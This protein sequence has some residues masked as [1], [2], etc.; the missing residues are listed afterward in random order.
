M[1]WY[2]CVIA[3][4]ITTELCA[5]SCAYLGNGIVCREAEQ[6]LAY[7]VGTG[8]CDYFPYRWKDLEADTLMLQCLHLTGKPSCTICILAPIHR[9]DANGVSGCTE[10]LCALIIYDAGKGA[11]QGIPDLVIVSVLL[12]QVTWLC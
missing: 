7:A 6:V 12:I 8:C 4:V 9:T 2:C 10:L 3:A 5:C 1:Q 11:V